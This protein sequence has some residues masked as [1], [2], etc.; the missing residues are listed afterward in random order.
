MSA[1]AALAVKLIMLRVEAGMEGWAR[2]EGVL[3]GKPDGTKSLQGRSQ[4]EAEGERGS[5]D[6]PV[7]PKANRCMQ[8]V[9]LVTPWPPCPACLLIQA[10]VRPAAPY[11]T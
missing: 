10:T 8:A 2:K 11:G 3:G 4:Q 7:G 6:Y 9:D 5:A 1:A